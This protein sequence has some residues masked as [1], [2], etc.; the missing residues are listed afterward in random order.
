MSKKPIKEKIHAKGVDITIYTEDFRNE[1]ISLTDIARYKSDEP[2]IVINNWMR[3]KDT[4]EFLGLWEQLHNLDFKPIEFDRF[5]KEAGYNAFTLSP[6]K[7]IEN[8]N[9]IGIVSKSGRYGGTFAHSDIAFEFASWISAEFKLYIIKDYK[10]LKNDESSRLSL[11]WNL[12]REISKLNYRIHTDAIKGNLLPPELTPFQISMTY[13]SEA[14]VLNVALFG[15]TA[16]QWREEH[17]DKS[18]NIRDYA[19]LNQL[20]VLANME[21]YNAILIEQGKPQSERLQLLNQLAIRQLAA[22]QEIGTETIKKLE[23]R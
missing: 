14:D 6:Q 8:T 2:F 5:R 13:A 4:I 17:P 19:T 15:I 9:A 20:L 10:R 16:K 7:W 21:S 3:G 23:G 11:G 18:G 12:N 1:F 22:I